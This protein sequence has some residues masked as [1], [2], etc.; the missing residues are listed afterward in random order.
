MTL[1]EIIDQ[2]KSL[3]NKSFLSS[4]DDEIYRDDITALTAAIEI[5][6]SASSGKTYT[7]F[8]IIRLVQDTVSEAICRLDTESELLC[9][10]AEE[11]AEL[12]QA[13]LKERRALE[14][15]NPTPV[16]YNQAH[17]NLL[18]EVADVYCCLGELLS[19]ADWETVAHIRAE[20]ENRWM[21]R[22]EESKNDETAL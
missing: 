12:A 17:I 1:A 8:E 20:K 16:S 18:E 3:V 2:L 21:Q 22:L 15:D 6:R 14:D 10:L 19:L 7:A 4:T 13:A 5:I 11:S 9:Q